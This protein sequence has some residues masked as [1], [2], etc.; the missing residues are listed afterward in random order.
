MKKLFLLSLL[1]LS[2][3]STYAA[4]TAPVATLYA[5]M[6]AVPVLTMVQ[7]DE[8]LMCTMDYNPVCGVNGTTYGNAC[9]A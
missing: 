5:D 8:P 6:T 9:G 3:S 2:V 1:A 4:D 7:V